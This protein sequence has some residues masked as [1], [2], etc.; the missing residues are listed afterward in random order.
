MAKTGFM[1]MVI[2]GKL[3]EILVKLA[4]DERRTQTTIVEQALRN[5]FKS[6]K[7]YKE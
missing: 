3:K 1:G 7:L 6:K 2:E 4:K 5:Y